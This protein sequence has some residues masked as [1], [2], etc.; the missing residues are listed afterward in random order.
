MA[1]I[2]VQCTLLFFISS[3]YLSVRL[4]VCCLCTCVTVYVPAC[5]P[6]SLSVCISLY[7]N[8][9]LF[10]VGQLAPRSSDI[11]I[12]N[13]QHFFLLNTFL[14]VQ[15]V[16]TYACQSA[17]FSIFILIIYRGCRFRRRILIS[18]MFNF[19]GYIFSLESGL[20]FCNEIQHSKTLIL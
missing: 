16:H 1:T 7:M 2:S 14:S 12:Q 19:R 6:V 17:L 10:L 15:S 9:P 11:T 13:L 18:D 5:L 4:Y 3:V 8:L 20:P